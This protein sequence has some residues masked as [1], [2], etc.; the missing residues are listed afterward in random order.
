MLKRQ[1]RYRVS[2]FSFWGLAV[3]ASVGDMFPEFSILSLSSHGSRPVR[4]ADKGTTTLVG[5]GKR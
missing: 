2:F 4:H 3:E 5:V 1:V